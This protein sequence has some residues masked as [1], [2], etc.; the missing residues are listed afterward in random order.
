MTKTK[1]SAPAE[2]EART[3]KALKRT[4]TEEENQS[5]LPVVPAE[6]PV[7]PA[8]L[9]AVSAELPAVSAELPAV[10]AEAALNVPDSRLRDEVQALLIGLDL[11]TT[12]IGELR[13]RLEV[14]L[15]LDAGMLASRKSL[16][17]RV[18]FVVQHEVLRKTSRSAECESL[19]K[20]LL[21]LEDAAVRQMLIDSLPHAALVAGSHDALQ[22]YQLRLL[23]IVQD[24]LVER[25][26]S[27]DTEASALEAEARSAEAELQSQDAAIAALVSAETAAKAASARAKALVEESEAET[28][29]LTQ[30]LESAAG[31]ITK[32]LKESE[33]L[34][35]ERAGF[36]AIQKGP[37]DVLAKGTWDSDQ[38]WWEAFAALQQ[39]LLDTGAESSLL[40]AATVSL[41]KRPADR[42]PFDNMAVNGM[43]GF[44][45]EQLT[46]AD[47]KLAQRGRIEMEAE[48]S[49]M[50]L[51]S[52]VDAM[53]A[54]LVNFNQAAADAVAAEVTI[55]QQLESTKTALPQRHDAAVQL[56]ASHQQAVEKLRSLDEALSLLD[57]WISGNEVP[58]LSG[59]TSD[60]TPEAASAPEE[61]EDVPEDTQMQ[62]AA[63]EN[64]E[65]SENLDEV[66]AQV[67]PQKGI[68]A[69]E[70]SL[71]GEKQEMSREDV[72]MSPRRV[73]T[74]MKVL[75]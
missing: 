35:E 66:P 23:G 28:A 52:L 20:E 64:S 8:E 13:G 51:S 37:A 29:Q 10:S 43:T 71:G 32:T 14:R 41:K 19:V 25:R 39:H 40:D 6:L 44:L 46:A 60:E 36:E 5:P 48:T 18:C 31:K 55:T 26:T 11:T 4:F 3:S 7:V 68:N 33:R 49:K 22:P 61:D 73:P 1:A 62:D 30:E 72:V 47:A 12:T 9:P 56:Q 70:P 45:D 34:R 21:Q 57:R 42:S 15:G 67:S 69:E 59:K 58:G 65:N 54:R 38:A 63:P 74:P 27:L 50:S 24:A 17:R 16:R 2:D 75:A 53:R